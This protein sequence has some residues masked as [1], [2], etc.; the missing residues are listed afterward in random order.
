MNYVEYSRCRYKY[1]LF[2][3][4]AEI[5]NPYYWIDDNE[6]MRPTDAEI[7]TLEEAVKIM[8]ATSI[9]N[10]NAAKGYRVERTQTDN[11]IYNL[12]D[13]LLKK[14]I[15]CLGKKYTYF[16]DHVIY[17]IDRN[18][19]QISFHIHHWDSEWK[20]ILEYTNIQPIVWDEVKNS[21]YYISSLPII[22]MI[23]VEC[24]NSQIEKISK[25][26]DPLCQAM[27]ELKNEKYIE[28]YSGCGYYIN[29]KDD[30]FSSDVTFNNA[31]INSWA[32]DSLTIEQ[33][34]E[35]NIHKFDLF[36]RS[37]FWVLNELTRV[38]GKKY[39]TRKLLKKTA[40]EAIEK[41]REII[42]QQPPDYNY[43][44]FHPKY[45]EKY[46]E[47]KEIGEQQA[48]RYRQLFEKLEVLDKKEKKLKDE[49]FKATHNLIEAYNWNEVFHL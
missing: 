9:A 8:I 30:S 21:A 25:E 10:N 42:M 43:A 20:K 3:Y 26:K 11:D 35:T 14:V 44:K 41:Y 23:Q 32:R 47:L 7:P 22:N 4:F 49:L 13:I 38:Y 1:N 12:K 29:H 40:D 28:T 31:V 27:T 37:D 39:G 6:Y 33:L 16:D 18:G 5:A 45:I 2:E 34:K 48:T 46:N 36:K 19:K 17:F 15:K 24:I